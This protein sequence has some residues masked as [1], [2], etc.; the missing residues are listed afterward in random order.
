MSQDI[1]GISI[2]L[3]KQLLIRT[4]DWNISVLIFLHVYGSQYF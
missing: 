3:N 1:S 2:F 4:D